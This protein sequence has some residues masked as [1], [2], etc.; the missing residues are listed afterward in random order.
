MY[1]SQRY[2]DMSDAYRAM[3][4][5]K[6]YQE[7]GTVG[8]DD[9]TSKKPVVFPMPIIPGRMINKKTEVNIEVN[10]EKAKVGE[11]EKAY[12]AYPA[13]FDPTNREDITRKG[14]TN[15]SVEEDLTDE[16]FFNYMVEQ[17][18]CENQTNS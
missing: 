8:K 5:A 14:T 2:P 6:G 12:Y 10:P 3:Y 4:E 7:G 1:D 17:G 16:E 11:V 9:T 18:L 13:G 15:E